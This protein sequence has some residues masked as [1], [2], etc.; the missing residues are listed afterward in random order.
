MRSAS[1]AESAPTSRCASVQSLFVSRKDFMPSG[2]DLARAGLDFR[3][4]CL[5]R[6]RNDDDLLFAIQIQECDV[7]LEREAGLFRREI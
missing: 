1:A 6:G 3:K 2:H 4:I 7:S 5:L